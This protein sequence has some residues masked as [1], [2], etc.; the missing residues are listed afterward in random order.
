V[1]TPDDTWRS[2]YAS[3]A[4]ARACL[5]GL[6][7]RHGIPARAERGVDYAEAW[8]NGSWVRLVPFEEDVEDAGGGSVEAVE[9]TDSESVEAVPEE[10]YV[11]VTYFDQGT[12]LTNV[13]TWRQTRLTRF[14][15]GYFQTWY[16][17][18][19]SEGEGL[20][21]WSLAEDE[22]WLFGGLRNPRGEARFVSRRVVVAPGD[23]VSFDLDVGIPLAEWDSSDLIQ[24]EWDAEASIDVIRDAETQDLD[25]VAAGTRLF[26]LT[27]SG[28]ES[29]FRHLLALRTTDWESL[30]VAFVP[31]QIAGLP[32]HPPDQGVLTI[33]AETAERI[34]DIKTPKD[35]LPLTILLDEEDNT[36]IWLRGM[37]GDMGKHVLRVLDQP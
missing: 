23:S 18:Q 20:V 27:L 3:P 30:D 35:H 8:E 1:A 14:K 37:R 25:D 28:H 31:I 7:R 9:E 24:Q 13:E 15:D 22:Y 34:F 4:S 29:S 36:L 21:E 2:G 11:A 17:G 10:G 12:P 5:V 26:V 32:D 19:L 33:D 16:L 6:L